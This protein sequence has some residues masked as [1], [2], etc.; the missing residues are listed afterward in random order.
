M[1]AGLYHENYRTDEHIFQTWFVRAWLVVFLIGCAVLP[2]FASK[3]MISILIEVGDNCVVPF[4]TEG[5]FKRNDIAGLG[6]E[7]RRRLSE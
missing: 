2:V 3:Y 7:S 4:P 5:V 6:E 1:P